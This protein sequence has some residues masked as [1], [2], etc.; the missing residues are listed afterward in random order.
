M[1]RYT[2]FIEFYTCLDNDFSTLI[3]NG[4]NFQFSQAFVRN[5][6]VN[7][8]VLNR[9]KYRSCLFPL[10]MSCRGVICVLSVYY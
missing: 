4:N 5:R 6:Q 8:T 10:K 9:G 7:L 1:Q 2:T 3:E